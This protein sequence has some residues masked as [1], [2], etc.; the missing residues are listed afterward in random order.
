MNRGTHVRC[1]SWGCASLAIL[2]VGALIW[3]LSSLWYGN[4]GTQ[5]TIN[6]RLTSLV[7]N[8]TGTMFVSTANRQVQVWQLHDGR[9]Q[10]QWEQQL[11]P[12]VNAVFSPDGDTI[13]TACTNGRV[14][15]VETLTGSVHRTFDAHTRSVGEVAWSP[16]GQHLASAEKEITVW[17]LRDEQRTTLSDHED[18]VIALAFSSDNRFLASAA[19][20]DEAIRIWDVANAQL[21]HRLPTEYSFTSG[22]AWS[23][24][25]RTLA[26]VS[27]D[28]TI[29]LWDTTTGVL[30]RQLTGHPYAINSVAW[31]PDG[32]LLATA[33]GERGFFEW[34]RDGAIYLWD[35]TEG[36][37]VRRLR[38][39]KNAI[40]S[41]T[42][43]SD[44]GILASASDDQSM[45]V[46][47]L[48]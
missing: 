13:A 36:R 24:D 28:G 20:N 38:G 14:C 25:G 6:R 21:V 39:H 34:Q 17:N 33:S 22:I 2:V 23:S 37:V 15:L 35:V 8:H 27:W 43:S 5:Y 4:A 3:Y 19:G 16:D 42:F 31:S 10:L 44:G 47:R 46:W 1:R 29:R 18:F 40:R 9:L 12:G 30:E 26:S 45:R 48:R 41:L 7:A 32:Q 11:G